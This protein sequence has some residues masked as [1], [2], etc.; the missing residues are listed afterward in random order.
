[1][2]LEVIMIL[3]DEWKNLRERKKSSM[4]SQLTFDAGSRCQSESRHDPRRMTVTPFQH[5]CRPSL[6]VFIILWYES[7]CESIIRVIA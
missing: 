4:N 3:G 2:I 1:M 6:P 5:L 7:Y